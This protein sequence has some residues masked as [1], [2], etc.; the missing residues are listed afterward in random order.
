MYPGFEAQGA[1]VQTIHMATT[2]SIRE[3]IPFH[4]MIGVLEKMMDKQR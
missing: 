3:R 2:R 1:G 4:I